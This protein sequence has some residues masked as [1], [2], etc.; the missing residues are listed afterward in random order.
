[1]S[2][3]CLLSIFHRLCIHANLVQFHNW[4]EIVLIQMLP[5]AG[6]TPKKEYDTLHVGVAYTKHPFGVGPYSK[7]PS[8]LV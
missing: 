5:V 6:T 8:F 3:E 1:M 4:L 7:S 2:T